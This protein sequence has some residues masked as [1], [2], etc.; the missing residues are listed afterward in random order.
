MLELLPSDSDLDGRYLAV[1]RLYRT[2][3]AQ[4]AGGQHAHGPRPGSGEEPEAAVLPQRDLGDELVTGAEQPGVPG[5]HRGAAVDDPAFHHR[6][7]SGGRRLG[8]P[9]DRRAA[10]AG[11]QRASPSSIGTPTSDPY[12]V[13]EPS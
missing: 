13:Q 7:A 9:A 11:A 2:L 4:A 6:L 3:G 8:G 5:S 10:P 12:S 1:I